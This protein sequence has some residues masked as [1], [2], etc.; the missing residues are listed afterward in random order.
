MNS[1]GMTPKIKKKRVNVLNRAL[2]DILF[3]PV[4]TTPVYTLE[5]PYQG[6]LMRFGLPNFVQVSYARLSPFLVGRVEFDVG[7]FSISFERHSSMNW[8]RILYILFVGI[9]A[10]GSATV[11]SLKAAS[12]RRGNIPLW[13]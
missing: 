9:V 8:K 1:K 13:V 3:P 5:N 4:K 12:R 6:E 11:L 7:K 10:L 2:G